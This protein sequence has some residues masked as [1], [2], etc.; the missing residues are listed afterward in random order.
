MRKWLD[1]IGSLVGSK[2]VL[3]GLITAM[4]LLCFYDPTRNA[5]ITLWKHSFSGASLAGIDIGKIISN[6]YF[7]ILVLF[8]VVCVGCIALYSVL[9]SKLEWN[10]SFRCEECR[11]AEKLKKRLE[12]R[13]SRQLAG[14]G[15]FATFS[16]VVSLF[17]TV[18]IPFLAQ[19]SDI[20]RNMLPTVLPDSMS[21]V[22]VIG[23][24]VAYVQLRKNPDREINVFG[25]FAF[26]AV[27]A[28]ALSLLIP[29]GFVVCAVA[30][31][32]ALA[33]LPGKF[34]SREDVKNAAASLMWFVVDFC[35]LMEVLFTL[36]E[37]GLLSANF[38]VLAIVS[39]LLLAAVGILLP[40]IRK[41]GNWIAAHRETV[42]CLGGLVS[43][44]MLGHVGISY[45]SL[46]DYRD[47]AYIYEM[48]NKMVAV[49]TLQKGA[50]P[51]L[52]YF[53]A[54][55]LFDV[56]TQI[57]HGFIH[58]NVAG[59][60]INPYEGLTSVLCVVVLFFLLKK[61]FDPYFA[62]LFLAFFPLDSLGL[63]SYTLCLVAILLNL[64]LTRNERGGVRGILQL[65]LF[66]T[67]IAANA[68]FI[69]DDGIALGV[70]A[71]F[72]MLV[73]YAC[74]RNW[75]SALRFL[76]MGGAVGAVVLAL[77]GLYCYLNHID[78]LERIQEWLALSAGANSVWAT[79]EFG[80]PHK[81]AYY[82]S[83][84]LLP[85]VASFIFIFTT[86]YCIK[87]RKVTLFAA[88]SF[89]FSLAELL[90]IP[91]GIV[92]H[93]LWMCNGTTGRLLN[94]S[95]FTWSFFAMFL[96][97]RKKETVKGLA[98]VWLFVIA[99]CVWLS[100]AVV[101][102]Y[103][104]NT[105]SALYNHSAAASVTA[106]ETFREDYVQ[107]RYA[108]DEQTKALID[109][110]KEVFDTLLKKDET[111][112]DFANMTS[113]YAMTG[114][115]RPF[116]VAQSPSLLTN[117]KSQEM[118]L[119]EVGNSKIPLAITGVTDVPYT[120]SIGGVPHHIRYY[121]VAEYIYARYVPLTQVGDFAIWCEKERFKEYSEKLKNKTDIKW[122]DEYFHVALQKLPYVWAN[123]DAKKTAEHGYP[124][125]ECT[126]SDS[127]YNL[128][129]YRDGEA[130]ASIVIESPEASK[131]EIILSGRDKTEWSYS[132]KF[133][134]EPGENKYLIRLNMNQNYYL[135]HT[136]Y[137]KI[138][139]DNCTVKE[140]GYPYRRPRYVY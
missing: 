49:D 39:W 11:L 129:G 66:W 84:Y 3:L 134:L 138:V 30:M 31:G 9:F 126:P 59:M 42:A 128:R 122:N 45:A 6:F 16:I 130:G 35:I 116:Y 85:F 106:Q 78:L 2:T 72:C 68:F 28:I 135:Y 38:R 51:V 112:L 137:A 46:W 23:M 121:K 77:C 14:L 119:H 40:R 8:P 21:V 44:G 57:I 47:F 53:S 82:Y 34:L 98:Y 118:F 97:T 29:V 139:C 103:L 75:K 100:N 12:S 71:I 60:L 5:S 111:F 52:D 123:L 32:V 1:H 26:Y 124:Y 131:A 48:G 114:R 136:G 27:S 74:R 17:S 115:E 101:T 92:W 104:P 65:T 61:A 96:V 67:L 87:N 62:F 107:D 15:V 7:M 93:N 120:Q 127:V 13:S 25:L 70:G 95:H 79:K 105:S 64:W 50:L 133:D 24:L 89:I 41:I 88:L 36:C 86:I 109:G 43:L 94:F 58:G 108:Y 113:L 56:W 4:V 63:K 91:R 54:H 22:F 110:F 10:P 69:Y 55:S 33:A 90:N 81:F 99:G 76:L 20:Y 140:F 37:K 102:F 73:V 132:F 18:G 19:R 83:Y 117:E 125:V 80:D